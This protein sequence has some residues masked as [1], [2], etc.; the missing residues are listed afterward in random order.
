MADLVLGMGF[1]VEP[2]LNDILNIIDLSCGAVFEMSENPNDREYTDDLKKAI[3]EL[4]ACLIFALAS[5]K[6]NKRLF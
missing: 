1:G 6:F 4:Y 5:Q 3:V 2:F